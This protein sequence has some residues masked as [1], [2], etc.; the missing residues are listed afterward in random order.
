MRAKELIKLNNEKQKQL[1]EEN[2]KD[3]E[4]MLT[5]IRLSSSK[6]EQQTE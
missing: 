2:A 6:S 5:Y 1:T 4:D 3:Y